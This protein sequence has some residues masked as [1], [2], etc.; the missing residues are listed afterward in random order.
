M[1]V[2]ASFDIRVLI[3]R[4]CTSEPGAWEAF[5]DRY[6]TRICSFAHRAADVIAMGESDRLELERDFVQEAY[7]KLVD[8][9]FHVLRSWRGDGD[10]SFRSY[11]HSIVHTV[12]C[13]EIRR[14]KSLKRRV[15]EV[16]IDADVPEGAL[17][18][19][20][21]IP[22]PDSLSPERQFVEAHGIAAFESLVLAA[23]PGPNGAR[24]ATVF[25]LHHLEDF[26]A[27]EIAEMPCFDLTV[28]NVESI[29]RRTRERARERM[30]SQKGATG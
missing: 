22:G 5:V 24:D 3:R 1:P 25:L 12:A 29:L 9:D 4:C 7:L 16:S 6:H 20:E 19:A 26:T 15:S 21:I 23:C 13:D 8:A 11:L 30:Q 10:D 27:R 2:D 18:L 14:R 28:P 17:P